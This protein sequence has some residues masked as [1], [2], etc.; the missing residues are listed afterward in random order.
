MWSSAAKCRR[1][2]SAAWSCGSAASPARSDDYDYVAKLA[3]AGFDAIDIEPTRVYNIEDARPIPD[4]R[5]ASTWTP[6]RRKWKA[7]S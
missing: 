3:S 7:N 1:R 2:F 5:K 4:Q 6:S